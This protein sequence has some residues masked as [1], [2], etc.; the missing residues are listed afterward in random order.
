MA[1][2]LRSDYEVPLLGMAE[3]SA[4]VADD[5]HS[6][7]PIGWLNFTQI[8]SLS[9]KLGLN[10]RPELIGGDENREDS[11]WHAIST[12]IKADVPV[13]LPINLGKFT[14]AKGYQHVRTKETDTDT[15][16]ALLAIGCNL[17]GDE[18]TLV[19]LDSATVPFLRIPFSAIVESIVRIKPAGHAFSSKL[20]GAAQI[21]PVLPA[22]VKLCLNTTLYGEK[23]RTIAPGLLFLI[24]DRLNHGPLHDRDRKVLSVSDFENGVWQ[25]RSR[26]VRGSIPYL[27]EGNWVYELSVGNRRWIWDAERPSHIGAEAEEFL[28]GSLPIPFESSPRPIQVAKQPVNSPAHQQSEAQIR[29]PLDAS[30]ILSLSGLGLR[31]SLAMLP[32]GVIYADLYCFMAQEAEAILNASNGQSVLTA[33]ANI[34]G[35]SHNVSESAQKIQHIIKASGKAIKFRALASFL[36]EIASPRD[37]ERNEVSN[38]LVFLRELSLALNQLGHE[39]RAIEITGG[40]RVDGV[41]LG[42]HPA[43]VENELLCV[44]ESSEEVLHNRLL[45]AISRA[46]AQTSDISIPYCL[47]IEPGPLFIIQTPEKALQLMVSAQRQYP[48]LITMGHLG[49]NFDLA[50]LGILRHEPSDSII[51]NLLPF[52]KH[53]HISDYSPGHLAD[54][55]LGDLHDSSHFVGWIR[56]LRR[57]TADGF[58]RTISLELECCRHGDD[59]AKAVLK[60]NELLNL[61]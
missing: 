32:E 18:R 53:V 42:K 57:S 17:G 38:A 41:W 23:K 34:A 11:L 61:D 54:I 33:M 36:P 1:A 26:K 6:E 48:N 21:F 55:P 30:V 60:L 45:S 16:H 4:L 2:V 10:V 51:N 12:F 22:A 58:S 9:S 37:H 59:V 8:Q 13:I 15:H 47:E 40:S 24:K 52:V 50:H 44:L 19:V 43:K 14:R 27:G 3:I 7:I 20:S 31:E 46:V 5:D 56:L 25:L 39:I 35:N 29:A 28:L 49:V